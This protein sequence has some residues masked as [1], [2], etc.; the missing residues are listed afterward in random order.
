MTEFLSGFLGALAVMALLS[1]GV[2]IGWQAHKTFVKHTT[3]VAEPLAEKERRKLSEEQ[4]AFD[5]V[6][7]YS[8]ERAYGMV[9][10]VLN[11]AGTGGDSR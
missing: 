10:D 11:S 9:D 7:N 5:M 8:M 2:A 3:H 6:R 4:Q 1:A